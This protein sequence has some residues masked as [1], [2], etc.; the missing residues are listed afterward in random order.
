MIKIL[1]SLYFGGNLN[2]MLS[3]KLKLGVSAEEIQNRVIDSLTNGTKVASYDIKKI[4][5]KGFNNNKKSELIDIIDLVSECIV[6]KYYSIEEFEEKYQKYIDYVKKYDN[7]K[8][9]TR[10]FKKI[11]FI[12]ISNGLFEL[13]L[14]F[15]ILC[16]KEYLNIFYRFKRIKIDDLLGV[17]WSLVHRGQMEELTKFIEQKKSLIFKK[18]DMKILYSVMKGEKEKAHSIAKKDYNE[19]DKMFE[20]LICGKNIAILGPAA[21]DID[22]DSIRDEFDI[23]IS[24]TYRG[25][26][27]LSGNVQSYN[28]D[29]SYYNCE[30][31]NRIQKINYEEFLY[32]LKFSVFKSIEYDYQKKLYQQKKCRKLFSLDNLVFEGQPNMLQIV[33]YDLLHFCPR[34]IKLFNFNLF[35]AKNAYQKGYKIEGTTHEGN[36]KLWKSYAIHNIITQYNF[37]KKLFDSGLIEADED[38][39]NVLSLGI[40]EYLQ[41][42]EKIQSINL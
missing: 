26:K 22:I 3:K 40:S 25:K 27:Y 33:L 13:S 38:G 24:L 4:L 5:H 15:R 36:F 37:S 20:K 2:D 8:L 9:S 21:G 12:C 35:L 42:M 23:L 29:V 7:T 1:L 30:A 32:E 16:E 41:Q 28:I 18:S 10:E 34:R 19:N 14:Q 6:L 31:G 39:E 17:F 11:E